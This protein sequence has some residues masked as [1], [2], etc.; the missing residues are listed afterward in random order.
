MR[1][2]MGMLPPL[3]SL[4]GA[5]TLK[6]PLLAV[7]LFQSTVGAHQSC[8]S[9]LHGKTSAQH[10]YP[11][12]AGLRM[13]HMEFD[14]TCHHQCNIPSM[15]LRTARVLTHCCVCILTPQGSW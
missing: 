3:P 15:L 14:F 10:W 13:F 4:E 12:T 8:D 7:Q 11:C 6:S 9:V 2:P 5:S 1:Y